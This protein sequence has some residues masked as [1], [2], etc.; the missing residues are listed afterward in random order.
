MALTQQSYPADR[1]EIIVIDNSDGSPSLDLSSFQ[2]Q[3]LNTKRSQVHMRRATR[4]SALREGRFSP[5]P[6]PTAFRGAIG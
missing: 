1:Y 3:E 5:S 4:A 6:M 2:K